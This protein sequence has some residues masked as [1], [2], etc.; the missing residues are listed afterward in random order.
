MQMFVRQLVH[1]WDVAKGAGQDAMLDRDLVAAAIPVAEEM[2]EMAGQGTLYGYRQT[3][4]PG[5]S[6]QAVLLGILGRREGW[7]PKG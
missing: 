4:S 6:R 5:A 2:V 1:G 3:V 7:V